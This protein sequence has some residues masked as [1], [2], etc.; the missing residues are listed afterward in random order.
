MLLQVNLALR[1]LPTFSCLPE[2]VGQHNT[3]IHLLPDTDEAHILS[4]LM[5][6][7]NDVMAGQLPEFPTIEWYIHTPV[8][9]S[10]QDEQGRHSSAL[11]VQVRA[12]AHALLRSAAACAPA[13][14]SPA[15]FAAPASPLPACTRRCAC[16]GF[17]ACHICVCVCCG[18]WVPPCPAGSSWEAEEDKFV[19][20]LLG[21]CDRFAPGEE[22]CPFQHGMRSQHAMQCA[23]P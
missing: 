16:F 2:R 3:T 14:P 9:P 21:I 11:F 13:V 22:Q 10:L 15:Y 23:W 20:H 17:Q 5:S 12:C 1:D 19:A 4:H 6:T 7:F 8:D 18:Q